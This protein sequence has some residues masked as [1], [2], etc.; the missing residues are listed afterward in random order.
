MKTFFATAE[1]RQTENII[2]QTGTKQ[3]DVYILV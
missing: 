2:E 3:S 1:S